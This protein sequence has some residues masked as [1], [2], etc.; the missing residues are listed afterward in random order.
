MLRNSSILGYQRLI[1]FP[2][3]SLSISRSPRLI[4]YACFLYGQKKDH[5]VNGQK[6]KEIIHIG[7]TNTMRQ[8]WAIL[9]AYQLLTNT[10]PS[11]FGKCW[12][13]VPPKSNSD[14]HL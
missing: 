7:S 4:L 13:C 8:I 11:H 2:T 9:I 5:C 1:K 12:L 14:H 3:A 6:L 10:Y